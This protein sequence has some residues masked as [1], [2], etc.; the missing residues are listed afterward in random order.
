MIHKIILQSSTVIQLMP[1][2]VVVCCPIRGAHWVMIGRTVLVTHTAS[3]MGAESLTHSKWWTMHVKAWVQVC[4]T[5]ECSEVFWVLY[6][7]GITLYGHYRYVRP[8]RV[9]FSAV[10]VINRVSIL[11]ILVINRVWFLIS[12]LKIGVFFK[13]SRRS[14]F[15]T[16]TDKND[17]QKTFRMPLTSV[18]K[19]KLS[20]R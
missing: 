17:Q 8:Q 10:F 5:K 2:F 19:W 20:N 11:A 12:S 3:F 15:F 13:I 18:W 4:K 14:Y 7:G 1:A 6:P 16:I 9:H